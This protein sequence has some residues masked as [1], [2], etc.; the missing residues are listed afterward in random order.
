MAL[1]E[2]GSDSVES[3]RYA[4]TPHLWALGVGA[5]IS[6]NFFGWQTGLVAGFNGL[7]INLSLVTVLYVLLAFSIAELSTTVPSGGGPYVFALHAIGPRAAFFAGQAESLKVVITCA[8]IVTGISSYM[9][10]L[11]NLSSDYGPIW[12]T[13][14]YVLFVSLNIIGVE[15]TF[16]VQAFTTLLKCRIQ[17]GSR[18]SIGSTL[19]VGMVQSR[20]TRSPCGFS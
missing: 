13:L 15:M 7:L 11:L 17:N 8:V 14:F 16:R 6:G 19:E 18:M 4:K 2:S 1:A 5:V 20:A 10:Q 3:L 12:W 9:N